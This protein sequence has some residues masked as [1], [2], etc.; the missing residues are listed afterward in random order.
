KMYNDRKQILK[1]LQD[2]ESEAADYAQW[3][4]QKSFDA[5]YYLTDLSKHEQEAF[6]RV[7][8]N[9]LGEHTPGEVLKKL[10]NRCTKLADYV[11][12]LA[13]SFPRYIPAD[14]QKFIER[15]FDRYRYLKLV[16]H[17][18]DD[19]ESIVASE[20]K[21]QARRFYQF[22]QRDV[23]L[24]EIVKS[25]SGVKFIVF[26]VDALGVEFIPYILRHAK[27]YTLQA[28]TEIYQA[29]L[30]TVTCYNT[31][32]R[33]SFE[34]RI[35]IR[36][37]KRIDE[38]KHRAIPDSQYE[39]TD[40]PI[41]LLE[42]LDEIDKLLKVS[43]QLLNSGEY[44][45]I[46]WISDHGASRLSVLSKTAK[47][48]NVSTKGEHGGRYCLDCDAL[49]NADDIVRVEIDDNRYVVNA[50][51]NRFSGDR[52][53]KP[54]VETHGGATLEEVLVPLVILSLPNLSQHI[55]IVNRTPQ[56]KFGPRICAQI[57]LFSKTPLTELTIRFTNRYIGQIV[58]GESED[59]QIY[60]FKCPFIKAS[61][62]YT[63]EILY[64]DDIIGHEAVKTVSTGM[65]MNNDLF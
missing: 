40:V 2:M 7:L 21:S 17:T 62:T 60:C 55:E 28:N 53:R 27:N 22:K 45:R 47:T 43:K 32:F 16:N 20:S 56:I 6:L 15:Y 61:G 5:L 50:G 19:F 39:K 9:H 44:D 33:Q 58:T 18:D 52:T 36:D 30:P 49:K 35:E 42:E 46:L 13:M 23:R 26:F 11:K 4:M 65:Q 29:N 14:D 10:E 54:T 8:S 3:V 12:P 34:N 57:Q 41:H 64:H 25:S 51:Y 37:I 59:G 48:I 31:Q 1:S 38:L 63:F 24:D